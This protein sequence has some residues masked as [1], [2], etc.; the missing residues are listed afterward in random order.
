M[1]WNPQSKKSIR[2]HNQ[3]LKRRTP[4]CSRG[5]NGRGRWKGKTNR[6]SD[7]GNSFSYLESGAIGRRIQVPKCVSHLISSLLATIPIYSSSS[8]LDLIG[9]PDRFRWRRRARRWSRWSYAGR[10]WYSTEDASK[11]S[12]GRE[13]TP[14]TTRAL[15]DARKNKEEEKN[16]PSPPLPSGGDPPE[17]DSVP[18]ERV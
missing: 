17:N 1:Y 6:R 8:V 7:G 15:Q 13:K 4:S 18:G 12:A 3:Y 14:S 10:S 9:D 5:S 11:F 16:D 2:G